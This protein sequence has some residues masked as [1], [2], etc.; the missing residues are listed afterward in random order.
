[1]P[2]NFLMFGKINRDVE[3]N[4]SSTKVYMIDMIDADGDSHSFPMTMYQFLQKEIVLDTYYLLI[5]RT[6][7]QK[8][9]ISRGKCR[10]NIPLLSSN[11]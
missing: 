11:N 2:C 5:G 4:S 1:M 7:L 9:R 6:V 3:V 10:I 8:K